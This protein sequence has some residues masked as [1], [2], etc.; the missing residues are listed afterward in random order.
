M[1]L[2]LIANIYLIICSGFSLGYGIA[3]IFKKGTLPTYFYFVLFAIL[4]T[5]LSRIFSTLSIAF[6]GGLPDSFTIGFLGYAASF[7]FIFFAN[8]GQMDLLIDDKD[9]KN[10]KYI[11][12][13]LIIPVLELFFAVLSLFIGKEALSIRISYVV[14]S[15]PAALAGYYNVKHMVVP[16]VDL[17]ILRSIRGYNLTAFLMGLLSLAEIGVSVYGRSDLDIYIQFMLGLTYAAVIHILI[18]EVKQWTK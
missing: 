9:R 7:L 10:P 6:N 3:E 12:I 1:D 17:G 15:V 13:S 11:L 14:I 18:K 5:F 8:F 2:F 4:S 16:D